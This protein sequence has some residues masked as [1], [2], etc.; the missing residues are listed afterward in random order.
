PSARSRPRRGSPRGGWSGASATSRRRRR[1]GPWARPPGPRRR[2]RGNQGRRHRS[3]APRSELAGRGSGAP[4]RQRSARRTSGVLPALPVVLVEEREQHDRDQNEEQLDDTLAQAH[5][6][7]PD[8]AAWTG[9]EYTTPPGASLPPL[10][11]YP[12]MSTQ[13]VPFP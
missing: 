12:P 11:Q 5:V 8:L 3:G 13:P 6:S 9:R 4:D 10:L 1:R 2:S 7:L